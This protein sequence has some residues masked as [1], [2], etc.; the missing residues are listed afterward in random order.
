[1][2]AIRMKFLAGRFHATPWGHH[3]N[4]GVVEYPPSLWRL[5]RSLVATFYR[6]FPE[7]AHENNGDNETVTLLKSLLEKLSVP[8]EFCLPKASV[9]HTRHYDQANNSVKFFDTFISVNQKDEIVWL[10]R[11][12]ELAD[13][14]REM[15]AELLASLGTFGRSESWCEAKLLSEEETRLILDEESGNFKLNS[16][17]SEANSSLNGMETM[18]LLLPDINTNTEEL[19]NTLLIETSAMRKQKQLEPTGSRWVTYTRPANILQPRRTTPIQ[20]KKQRLYTT[21]RFALSSAVLPLVTDAMPFAEMTR[22]ALSHNR[23]GNSYS[24]ALTGKTKDGVPLEGH[25]HAHFFVTDEDA[26]GRLDHLT[27]YAPCSF[28]RDDVEAFGQLRSVKRYGNLPNVRTVLLGLG[29]REDFEDVPIFK[30]SKRWRSVTPFSLP[31]FANRGGGK[32]PR[33]RDTPEGQ[34]KRELRNRN[35]PEPISITPVYG[36]SEN[37]LRVENIQ[38]TKPRFRWLEFHTR[39]LRKDTEGYGL[40]GFEIEFAESIAGPISLGFGCHFGLGLFM[41]VVSR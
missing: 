39:R 32:P 41:P 1:M 22:F 33:P 16:K 13:S 14:E 19:F 20:E 24:P 4:E 3:V 38:D 26:D 28:N 11:D 25:E 23:A 6:V 30:S 15:L 34:L 8:P 31:R 35:L 21:A 10:W 17:P 18:R 29:D 40:A 27:V 5:L 7:R 37:Q 36:Y 9:A 2:L 12:V